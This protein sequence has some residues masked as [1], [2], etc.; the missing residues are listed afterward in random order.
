VVSYGIVPPQRFHASSKEEEHHQHRISAERAGAQ[1][2]KQNDCAE[3][4]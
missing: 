3:S 4:G 1:M 2:N